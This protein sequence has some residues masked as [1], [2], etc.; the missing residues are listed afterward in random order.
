MQQTNLCLTLGLMLLTACHGAWA[1]FLGPLTLNAAYS[2]QSDTNLFRLPAGASSMAL[3]GRTDGAEQIGV[4]TLGFGFNTKQSLQQFELTATVVDYQYQHFNYLNY[5]ATNFNAA[6]RWA[7]TPRWHGN[8]TTSRNETQN[9]F[10]DFQGSSQRNLRLDT[11]YGVDT[12]YEIDGPWHLVA[13]L[14]NSR[15]A[16]QTMPVAGSDFSNMAVDLGVRY[17]FASGSNVTYRMRTNKGEYLHE[18]IPSNGLFDGDYKQLDRDLKLHWIASGN[19][20][21]DANLTY[22]TRSHP[23][24]ARQDFDGLNTGVNFNWF[25][26]GKTSVSVGYQRSLGVYETVGSNYSRTDSVTLGPVYQISPKAILRLQS[27]VDQ[28]DYLGSLIDVASSARR[29]INR[30]NSLTLNWQPSQKL[31]FGTSIGTVSRSSNQVGANYDAS[32]F[33]LSAQL[34]Y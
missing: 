5:T 26:S 27:R 30:S 8:L 11:A 1:Q 29:D 21:I 22:V 33:S 10:A 2:L 7:I 16:N 32:Q 15:Q 18:G 31:N 20:T 17:D 6:W 13:S 14:S 9:S 12:E 24:I 34:S 3:I 28:V 19:S 25:Y 4:S 23:N